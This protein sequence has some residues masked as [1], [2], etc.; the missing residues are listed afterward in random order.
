LATGGEDPGEPPAE[1]NVPYVDTPNGR[2]FQDD[3][4]EALSAKQAVEEGATIYKGFK[5][6]KSSPPE[7]SQFFALENPLSEGYAQKYGIPPTNLPFDYVKSGTLEPG[8]P[9]I[10]RPA[11]PVGPNGGGGIE[12]VTV[13]GGFRGMQ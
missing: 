7:Q 8:V 9:F 4:P 10:T 2:A 13:P 5:V 11:V 1:G 3:S 6:G 12:V